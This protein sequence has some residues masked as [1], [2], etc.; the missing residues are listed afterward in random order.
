MLAITV[1]RHDQII[2]FE[3]RKIEG[4]LQGGPVPEIVRMGYALNIAAMGQQLTGTVVRSVVH[5]QN[6]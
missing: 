1:D 3:D 2:P 5:H 4:R 6:V